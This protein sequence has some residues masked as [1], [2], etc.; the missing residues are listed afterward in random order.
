MHHLGNLA[1]RLCFG[2]NE[3]GGLAL[4]MR[5]HLI[6]SL[7]DWPKL[8]LVRKPHFKRRESVDDDDS[9]TD[10]EEDNDIIEVPYIRW[11]EEDDE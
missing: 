5:Y 9:S 1:K 3:G 7:A 11:D 6:L 8:S 10:I 4:F 2:K